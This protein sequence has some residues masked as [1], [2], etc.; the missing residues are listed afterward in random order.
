MDAAGRRAL[1]EELCSF[2]G[3]GP[4]TDAERRAANWLAAGLRDAGRRVTVEPTYVHPQYALAIAL[5]LAVAI[6]GSLIAALLSPAAGFALVLLAA[7]S[8]YLDQSTRAYLLRRL[9]FR[10]A[11]QNV[12]S[13]GGRPEAPVRVVLSAHYDAGRTG[14]VFGPRSVALA[15]RLAERWRLLLGPIRLLYWA[16]VVPLLAISGLRM[17]GA[18]GAALS[19]VQL[20]PIA[21]LLVAIALLVDIT[22]S[23]VVPGACDNASGVAAVLSAAQ[24]LDADPPAGLDLWVVL[25]G[26]EEANAQG[27]ARFVA[28]H[29]DDLDP[30][31][32]LFVNLDSVS[33]G[34]VHCERGEGAI[35]TYAM[36]SRLAEICAEVGEDTGIGSR[37]LRHPFH[38]DALPA[39]VRGYRAISL[40]GASDGVGAPYYHTHDDV[41]DNLDEV[42]LTRATAFTVALVRAI[43]ADANLAPE[44]APAGAG[45]RPAAHRV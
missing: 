43:A 15:H 44:P 42:A 38:T 30:E 20:A 16:G 28:A 34:E 41:P 21:L 31:R 32:T 37:P 45:V 27:M 29:R 13:P 14:L 7:V 25:P 19:A 26:A 11:S 24:D 5:H 4:G 6:A 33:Y 22:L 40:L 18:G 36:D 23:E 2:E 9:L 3:R 10:R 1:I 35:V 8:L 12:V 39:R 17:A